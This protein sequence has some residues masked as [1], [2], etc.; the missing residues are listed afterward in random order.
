[1]RT[2]TG[3]AR[4]RAQSHARIERTA[5]E[6]FRTNGFDRVTVEDVC[7]VAQVA[8]ATFYRH[9]GSKDEVVFAYQADFTAVLG[10]AV[11]RTAELAERDRLPAILCDFAGFLESQRDLLAVRD[12]IVVGHPRLMQRTLAVQ[13]EFEAALAGGLAKLRGLSAPDAAALLE[14]GVGMVV[15]RVALRTWRAEGGR[16]SLL[17]ATR[18]GMAELSALVGSVPATSS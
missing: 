13:R 14:A 8:P 16:G 11:G 3:R 7:A 18:R 5:L 17:V 2:A 15:L 12:E 4:S 1:M 10:A 6:L 9:F